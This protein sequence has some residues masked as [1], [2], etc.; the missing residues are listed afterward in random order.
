MLQ[1]N[2]DTKCFNSRA[3]ELCFVATGAKPLSFKFFLIHILGYVN[4]NGRQ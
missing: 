1:Q 2:L 4:A 3:D